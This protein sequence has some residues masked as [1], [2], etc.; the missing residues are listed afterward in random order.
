MNLPA[1]I[2][3]V[4]NAA[5]AGK[6]ISVLELRTSGTGFSRKRVRIYRNDSPGSHLAG[7]GHIPNGTGI[8]EADAGATGENGRVYPGR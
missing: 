2:R 7:N 4:C 6:S 1:G 5:G 8:I 3:I